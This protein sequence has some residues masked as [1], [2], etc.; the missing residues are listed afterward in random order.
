MIKFIVELQD[1][2]GWHFYYP[3]EAQD[4][5]GAKEV[6]SNAYTKDTVISVHEKIMEE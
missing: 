6:A 1:P 2:D 5:Y 4:A 3:C